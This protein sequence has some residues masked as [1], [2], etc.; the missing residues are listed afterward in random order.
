[1]L[2]GPEVLPRNFKCLLGAPGAHIPVEYLEVL[3]A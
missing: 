1:M 2:E 3:W